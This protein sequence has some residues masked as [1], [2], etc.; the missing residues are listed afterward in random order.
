M[1]ENQEALNAPES[2][3]EIAEEI[4]PEGLLREFRA[5]NEALDDRLNTLMDLVQ[6]IR[7]EIHVESQAELQRLA[8]AAEDMANGK[9]FQQID[10]QAKGELGALVQSIN[11]TL[12][13][14]QQLD[15]S[16]KH[17]ST[18][19]PELAAQLD[20]ITADTE[21]ATQTVM[22]RLDVLMAASDQAQATIKQAVKGLQTVQEAH[23]AFHAQMDTF[24]AKA[25]QGAEPAQ[26]AQEILEFV[27]EHQ[28]RTPPP[29]TDL[30]AC[31][32]PLN[33]VSDEAFEILNTLQ[34]QD[35]TRQKVEKVV[36][37]L[38]Q[39]KEGLGRLL[40]IFNIQ[41]FEGAAPGGEVFEHRATATQ[42]NIFDT[43]LQ[44]DDK[45]QSV[46]D[47]IAQ[48]KKAQG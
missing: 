25:S 14:L 29:A 44:A 35:I 13:N 22:N 41:G 43:T 23:A 17:Q 19:V 21:K 8:K 48:F 24:I 27:F 1:D 20:A 45:K 47:I 33:T 4:Q 3:P 32:A 16:V 9:I 10:I 34:F 2:A 39:F 37:L 46:D 40:A 12:L 30:E 15:S 7:S 28:M 36:L 26:L 11:S 6:T 5:R 38:K 31:I 18:Q 42:E